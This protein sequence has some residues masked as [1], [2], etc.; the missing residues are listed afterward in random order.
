MQVLHAQRGGALLQGRGRG[1][2]DALQRCRLPR[3]DQLVD[4]VLAVLD[5]R[6]GKAVRDGGSDAM[7]QAKLAIGEQPPPRRSLS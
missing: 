3:A 2:V 4:G 7:G 1:R 5:V 6:N